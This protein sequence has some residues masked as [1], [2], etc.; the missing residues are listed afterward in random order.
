ML[1]PADKNINELGIRKWNLKFIDSRMERHYKIQMT[2]FTAFYFR[3]IYV[4]LVFVFG[5]YI[6]GQSIET[7]EHVYTYSRLGVFLG[8][9][10]IGIPIFTPFFQIHYF[11]IALVVTVPI[12]DY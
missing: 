3:M 6:L 8:F 9:V 11:E 7:K 4:L 10:V 12:N 5:F 1:H 2:K